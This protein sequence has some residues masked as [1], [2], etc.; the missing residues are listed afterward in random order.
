MPGFTDED[1]GLSQPRSA[2]LS[3][4]DIG[5]PSNGAVLKRNNTKESLAAMPQ[6]QPEKVPMLDR[7]A[8][9]L[10]WPVY[11]MSSHNIGRV[12]ENTGAAVLNTLDPSAQGVIPRAVG[13]LMG[14]NTATRPKF[15][16]DTRMPVPGNGPDAYTPQPLEEKSVPVPYRFQPGQPS[17]DAQFAN[18]DTDPVNHVLGNLLRGMTTPGN[19]ASLPLAATKPVQALFLSQTVPGIQAGIEQAANPQVPTKERIE[20]GLEATI[21]AAMSH[22][23]ATHLGTPTPSAP[24]GLKPGDIPNWFN[25]IK[26]VP[27]E[28]LGPERQIADRPPETRF[29][30]SPAG[31]AADLSQLTPLE[32]LALL[33]KTMAEESVKRQYQPI[34]DLKQ[35]VIEQPILQPNPAQPG[36]IIPAWQASGSPKQ[37]GQ[38]SFASEAKSGAVPSAGQS[39]AGGY[40]TNPN[41]LTG[42]AAA[43]ELG[44]KRAVWDKD[45]PGIGGTQSFTEPS[46]GFTVEKVAPD[47]KLEEIALRIRNKL[48]DE[49]NK[50]GTTYYSNPFFD[51]EFWKRTGKDIGTAATELA[52]GRKAFKNWVDKAVSGESRPVGWS[53]YWMAPK[54]E[55]AKAILG[56]GEARKLEQ[57]TVGLDRQ[58]GEPD[59]PLQGVKNIITNVRNAVNK[60]D[61][62]L[63]VKDTIVDWLDNSKGKYDGTL[64]QHVVWPMDDNFQVELGLR[65]QHIEPVRRAI[66]AGNLTRTNAER[67]GVALIDAQEGGRQRLID[68]GVLPETIN[69]I[70]G[71]LTD[72]EKQVMGLM[73][74]SLDTTFPMVQKTAK[75]FKI[76]LKPED[77]YFSWQRD[78]QK[79]DAPPKDM[80]LPDQNTKATVHDVVG[81]VTDAF[82]SKGTKPASGFTIERKP[83]AA[84]PIKVNAFEVFER[85]IRDMAHFVAQAEHLKDVGEIVRNEKFAAK[86]GKMGQDMML[87]WLNTV[88]RQGRS[89]NSIPFMD[90]MRKRASVGILAYRVASQVIHSVNIPLGMF[91]SGPEFW[92]R[93]IVASF[94]EEGQDFLNKHF[95][96]TRERGGGEPGL[97]E[98]DARELTPKNAVG[99]GYEKFKSG[100]FA[101]QRW[102]DQKIAQA[103]AL[104]VYQ[105]LL[106]EKGLDA[107]KWATLPPDRAAIA[108]ARALSRRAVASPL[109]KDTPN[110]L[111][112]G[113]VAKLFFQFQNTFLDQW[114]NIRHDLPEYWKN[115]P[116]EGA[117]LTVALAVMLGMETAIKLGSKKGLQAA[118]GYSPKKEDEHPW[119]SKY[120]E[121]TLKRVPFMGQI[122]TVLGY[123]G[124]GIPAVDL[125]MDLARSG[126]STAQAFQNED[127]KTGKLASVQTATAAA[128]LAGVPGASQASEMVQNKMKAQM[129]KTHE[130]RVKETGQKMFGTKQFTL[131]Q[132]VE[133]EKQYKQER[134]PMSRGE[135]TSS[136]RAAIKNNQDRG[137]GI[138]DQLDKPTRVWLKQNGLKVPGHADRFAMGGADMTMSK[139]ELGKYETFLVEEYKTRIEQLNNKDFNELPNSSKKSI[140]DRQMASAAKVAR[141]RLKG[142]L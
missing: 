119:A 103:T 10:Y 116:A 40:R 25:P 85:H 80:A 118:S 121:E 48:A 69:R 22:G 71:S 36:D 59:K 26:D 64:A 24:S 104:G 86:Y 9:A 28:G 126:K 3:D 123:G 132:R 88:A 60:T 101:V 68:T 96:E 100:G 117:K 62:V 54:E 8:S 94:T 115:K 47:A 39:A 89:V 5:L 56:A 45:I 127:T 58:P 73:R 38:I 7:L 141:A 112:Q 35:P 1:I 17:T 76:D 93:G 19:L 61:K 72:S 79:F 92:R 74:K 128:E 98:I 49:G 46:Q 33:R 67:I 110:I 129:F 75:L 109:Y 125:F 113:S 137:A 51:P 2:G 102:L 44:V 131:E 12:M 43:D 135:Q 106:N 122:M 108:Q 4:A 34:Y 97:M 82:P 105:K 18:E 29:A 70:K 130:D 91:R 11:G 6:F 20:G 87:D 142:E 41:E 139:E 111:N 134:P 15:V 16:I 31:Q 99:K 83:G 120:M 136:A 124:I 107:G 37:G 65:D 90:A 50:R 53:P 13:D 95:G 78:F 133:A 30:V 63:M 23:L 32:Q 77:N 27:Q 21:A 55:R 14:Y 81:W 84:T 66:K 114:S 52:K 42:Q 57:K 138:E 140:F